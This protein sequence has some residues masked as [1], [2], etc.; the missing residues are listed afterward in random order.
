MV[1][2][3]TGSRQSIQL[4]AI[5]EMCRVTR[6]S[7]R[8]LHRA[9]LV[10]FVIRTVGE[11]TQR[12][13]RLDVNDTVEFPSTDHLLNH[14]VHLS[15]SWQI[16]HFVSHEDMWAVDIRIALV[17]TCVTGIDKRFLIHAPR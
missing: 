12:G 13:P 15:E 2:T 5:T 14:V 6:A 1:V 17:E 9:N 7:P 10:E 11:N 4:V 8:N 16:E 3:K